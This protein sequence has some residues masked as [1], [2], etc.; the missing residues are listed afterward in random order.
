M[1]NYPDAALLS[2]DDALR[3][4]LEDTLLDSEVQGLGL[5]APAKV[6]LGEADPV[7][8]LYCTVKDAFRAWEVPT[9]RN[10]VLLAES[11]DGTEFTTVKIH[12]DSKPKPKGADAPPPRPMGDAAQAMSCGCR[13]MNLRGLAHLP[14]RPGR[15]AFTLVDRDWKSNTEI[16]EIQVPDWDP[17]PERNAVPGKSLPAHWRASLSDAHARGWTAGFAAGPAVEPALRTQIEADPRGIRI[18][19]ASNL[20]VRPHHLLDAEFESAL[21]S[22]LQAAAVI[23]APVRLVAAVQNPREALSFLAILPLPLPSRPSPGESLSFT[24]EFKLVDHPEWINSSERFWFYLAAGD[25]VVGPE[26]AEFP[27]DA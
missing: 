2:G 25:T 26:R 6:R 7:P 10:L 22:E 9:K 3:R 23:A 8:A 11:L 14:R 16:V 21:A 15:Y 24:F 5:A 13:Y 17:G 18:S 12:A 20:V 4:D 27:S 1:D 19:G